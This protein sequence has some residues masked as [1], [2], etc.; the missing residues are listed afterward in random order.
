VLYS[1]GNFSGGDKVV[2]S[3]DT[4]NITYTTSC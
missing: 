3:G 2:G 4:L 1:A